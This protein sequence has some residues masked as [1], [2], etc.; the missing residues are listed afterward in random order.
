M[1]N[2]IKNVDCNDDLF[3]TD[4]FKKIIF[5]E[6]SGVL[7]YKIDGDIQV[8]KPSNYLVKSINNLKQIIKD[9][10]SKLIIVWNDLYDGQLPYTLSDWELPKAIIHLLINDYGLRIDGIAKVLTNSENK[11]RIESPLDLAKKWLGKIESKIVY[12]KQ[13]PFSYFK[14]GIAS[15]SCLSSRG[16]NK[17]LGKSIVYFLNRNEA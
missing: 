14:D 5:C 13:S 11:M 4:N 9:T 15:I 3:I 6:V 7:T 2:T 10:N 16:L 12:I 1:K 17:E 8:I